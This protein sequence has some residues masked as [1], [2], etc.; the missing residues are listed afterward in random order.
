MSIS[1]HKTET[2]KHNI[3][4]STSQG[5]QPND[6]ID[7]IID[8]TNQ[9]EVLAEYE[10]IRKISYNEIKPNVE[11][12]KNAD[13]EWIGGNS[14]AYT[15]AKKQE[16][17][18]VKKLNKHR[19]RRCSY[20]DNINRELC[21]KNAEKRDKIA[22][23]N[24]T[25]Y[26]GDELEYLRIKKELRQQTQAKYYDKN[27]EKLLLKKKLKYVKSKIK[28]TK[29]DKQNA[30]NGLQ[31]LFTTRGIIKPMC[32]CGR[33]CDVVKNLRK[34]STLEKHKLFK[35]II[36]LIHYNRRYN[37]I[38]PVVD[39][40]NYDY[41]DYKRVV[42]EKLNGKSYTITNKT[43]KEIIQL[44][45]DL[46][47]PIDESKTHQPRKSY[48]NKKKYTQDYKNNVELMSYYINGKLE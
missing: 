40:I 48:I 47:N 25:F 44:Y 9:A 35:S 17:E 6:E 13:N 23:E 1:I 30:D 43:D 41:I 21:F 33:K 8:E 7:K 26:N 36:K 16:R 3:I 2:P 38:K 42:R 29:E 24:G 27:R 45:N 11:E 22:K 12:F 15:E 34:H 32:I 46:I 31:H 10:R 4:I 19:D 20:L 37:S 18:R 5:D 14:K 28:Q 39:K